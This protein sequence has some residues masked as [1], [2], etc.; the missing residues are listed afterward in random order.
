MLANIDND[1]AFLVNER[2]V[3]RFFEH[4]RSYGDIPRYKTNTLFTTLSV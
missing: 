3:L 1:D 2:G 4:A